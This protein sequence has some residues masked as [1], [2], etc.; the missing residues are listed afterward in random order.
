MLGQTF[1]DPLFFLPYSFGVMTLRHASSQNVFEFGAG[2]DDP[3][4]TAMKLAVFFIAYDK[5]VVA[6]VISEAI[7]NRVDRAGHLRN[8]AHAQ[9]YHPGGS[10]NQKQDQSSRPCQ[11]DIEPIK[12]R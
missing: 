5:A 11:H 2:L 10:I 3:R 7:L 4:G 9:L 12:P 1:L 8:G 6:V